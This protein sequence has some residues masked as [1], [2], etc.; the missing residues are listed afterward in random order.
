M[1][2][3]MHR[4]GTPTP[5]A[6]KPINLGYCIYSVLEDH[7]CS[8]GVDCEWQPAVLVAIPGATPEEARNRVTSLM[9]Q[10]R[11]AKSRRAATR[12]AE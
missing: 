4:S 12:A 1:R 11:E 5:V 3:A 6:R 9:A 10:L 8:R 2:A 7:D